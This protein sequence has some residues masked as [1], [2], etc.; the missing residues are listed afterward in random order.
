MWE[1]PLLMALT[2][3]STWQWILGHRGE[4]FTRRKTLEKEFPGVSVGDEPAVL[5]D[6]TFS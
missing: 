3:A 1:L 5:Y 6:T 2:G 4:A